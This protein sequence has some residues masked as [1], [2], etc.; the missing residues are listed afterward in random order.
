MWE[1]GYSPNNLGSR[2]ALIVI[3]NPGSLRDLLERSET[4]VARAS[5]SC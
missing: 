3:G 4:L 1:R 2:R 5:I